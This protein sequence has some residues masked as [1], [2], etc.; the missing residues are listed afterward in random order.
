MIAH[1]PV[2]FQRDL[3]FTYA[4][5]AQSTF[6]GNLFTPCQT[7]FM[8]SEVQSADGWLHV[9]PRLWQPCSFIATIQWPHL[10]TEK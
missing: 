1:I 3:E 10:P 2:L 5:L 8:Q 7:G 9:I 6:K 4:K